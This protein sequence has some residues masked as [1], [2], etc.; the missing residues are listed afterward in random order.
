[1]DG[2]SYRLES[3]VSAREYPMCDDTFTTRV[4]TNMQGYK[5]VIDFLEYQ[6]I[7]LE[8]FRFM[9]IN[10]IG[11]DLF[12]T[13]H[14]WIMLLKIEINCVMKEWEISTQ[15]SCSWGEKKQSLECH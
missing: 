4:A 8:Y 2:G 6:N 3:G 13:L 5:K 15:C 1:M 12:I 9:L 10:C 11:N 7:I 14:I